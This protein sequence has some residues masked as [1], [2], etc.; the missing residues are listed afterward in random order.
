MMNKDQSSQ[1]KPTFWVGNWN[2]Y[3]LFSQTPIPQQQF[4]LTFFKVWQKDKRAP[5]SLT[6]VYLCTSSTAQGGGG[7]FKIK[8]PDNPTCYQLL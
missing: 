8:G 5:N 6:D 2:Y 1:N 7:S 3:K 4:A